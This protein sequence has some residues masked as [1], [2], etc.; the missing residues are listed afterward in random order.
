[1]LLNTFDILSEYAKQRNFQH[2]WVSNVMQFDK[3]QYSLE[4]HES[5]GIIGCYDH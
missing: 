2:L 3:M 5:W 4:S 1:M